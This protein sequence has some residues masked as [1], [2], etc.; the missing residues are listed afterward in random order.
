MPELTQDVREYLLKPT[1]KSKIWTT[2]QEVHLL[3]D[4]KC[5]YVTKIIVKKSHN[6]DIFFPF[7]IFS[8]KKA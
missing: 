7:R 1:A 2:Q 5:Y 6:T 4:R 8:N 3:H